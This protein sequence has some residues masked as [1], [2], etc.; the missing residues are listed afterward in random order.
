MKVLNLHY[1][2]LNERRESYRKYQQKCA[3]IVN[4]DISMQ[5][6]M[7]SQCQTKQQ[8]YVC[9]YKYERAANI[10][11]KREVCACPTVNSLNNKAQLHDNCIKMK[12]EHVKQVKS[13][14][15]QNNTVYVALPQ[16]KS[17][18]SQYLSSNEIPKGKKSRLY[19]EV[20]T[21]YFISVLFPMTTNVKDQLNVQKS[22][23]LVLMEEHATRCRVNEF[24]IEQSR[25]QKHT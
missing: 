8:N 16:G 20:E 22:S 23:C 25:T 24:N 4:L 17:Q 21:L 10:F 13:K 9:I 7:T 2:I 15:R 11:S 14:Q 1:Y 5:T 12:K 19:V 18:V 3:V 6:N